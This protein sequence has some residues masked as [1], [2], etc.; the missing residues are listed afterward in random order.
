MEAQTKTAESK[1]IKQA[2]WKTEIQ[3]SIR[4]VD[5]L[6]TFLSL[7]KKE[8]AKLSEVTKRFQ[9]AIT[10]YY[11]KLIDINNPYDPIKRLVVPSEEELSVEGYFDTSGEEDNT[12][13][14][15]LQHKYDNTALLLPTPVCTSYCRYCF[16]KRLTLSNMAKFE[17]AVDWEKTFD[18]LREHTEIDNVLI[19][20][21]DPMM[22]SNE[23]IEYMLQNFR[24]IDHIKMI[25]IGTKFLSFNPFR[26]MDDELVGIFKR[27]STNDKKIYIVAHYDHPRELTKES[28]EAVDLLVNNG[29]PLLNQCVLHRGIN[30]SPEII[31]DLHN[32]LYAAGVAPYY[33]FQMRPVKGSLQFRLPLIEGLRIFERAKRKMSGPAKRVRFI[34]S[35]YT[36]KIEIFGT[37]EVN[38]KEH[39]IL[40]YHQARNKEDIGRIIIAPVKEDAYWLS[41]LVDVE[42]ICTAD[43]K[44]NIVEDKNI[45]GKTAQIET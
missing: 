34:M 44:E 42:E 36:G 32:R 10:P 15:G 41:D 45:N 40:K 21:G 27:Y 25:R 31:A 22:L 33:L 4:T 38:G 30:D 6:K 11:A 43:E 35:H 2:R 29:I 14:R 20:G 8:T 12:K 39:I 24:E 7:S 13:V 1:V 5:Q 3:K 18:Y 9:M 37:T 28:L 26:F 23:K 17:T 16:R 19:T